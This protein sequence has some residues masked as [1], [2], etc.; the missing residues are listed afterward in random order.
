M[1]V[2]EMFLVVKGMMPRILRAKTQKRVLRL[3]FFI[4]GDMHKFS[5]HNSLKLPDRMIGHAFN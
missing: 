3:P 5:P 1:L 2:L 4:K